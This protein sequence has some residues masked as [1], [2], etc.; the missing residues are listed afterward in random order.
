MPIDDLIK[1]FN[2]QAK[3]KAEDAQPA[4]L[5]NVQKL[6][7]QFNQTANNKKKNDVNTKKLIKN[8]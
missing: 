3:P 8:K 7:Q 4:E 5:T 2:N 1:K 6:A